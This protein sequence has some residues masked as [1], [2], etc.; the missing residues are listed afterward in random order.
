MKWKII[1]LVI[2]ACGGLALWLNAGGNDAEAYTTR[3]VPVKDKRRDEVCTVTR[4]LLAFCNRRGASAA[5]RIFSHSRAARETAKAE[6]GVDPVRE[7][8]DVLKRN[9]PQLS[10]QEPEVKCL[11]N[12]E[13]SFIVTC[14]LREDGAPVSIRMR[15]TSKGYALNEIRE[16]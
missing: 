6:T 16:H 10:L 1:L 7:S 8:L 15:K 14:R 9:G 12:A 13:N 5:E 2:C 3:E 4:E 11:S